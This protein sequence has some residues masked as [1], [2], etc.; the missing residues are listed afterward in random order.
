VN[1][2]ALGKEPWRLK[3]LEDQLNMYRQKW[4]A[5]QKKTIIAKMA[6]KIPG[7]TNEGKMKNSEINNHNSS[8][9]RSGGRQGNNGRGGH[10]GRGRGRGGRGH[11]NSE[12]L[13]NVDFG[14]LFYLL[15]NSKKK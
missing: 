9:G 6:G 1:F 8:G 5:V 15:L 12:H 10:R 4:Q 2:L 11:N 14:S 3:D 13:K 7:K